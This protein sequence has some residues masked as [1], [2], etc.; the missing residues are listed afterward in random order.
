VD[1]VCDAVVDRVRVRRGRAEGVEVAVRGERRMASA[2][3]VV[4]A[5]G[6]VASPLVLMRS[7]LGPAS[8]LSRHGIAPVADLPRVGANLHDHLLAAGNVYRATRPVPPSRLQHSE[9]LMYVRR[10]PGPAPDLV[11]ACV[12]LPVVSEAFAAPPV[13]AAFTIMCGFTHPRS[14]GRVGLGGPGAL[15]PPVIDPAYLAE[16][17]DRE[18]FRAS[19][20]LAREVAG[21]RALDP[22]RSEELLPGPAVRTAAGLDDFLARAAVTHHHPVGTCGMGRE[23]AAAVVDGA[24]RVHGVERLRIADASV[25]PAITTGPVNATVVAVAERAAEL[26]A[27]A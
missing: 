24:L 5:A 16:P 7:G 21:R 6:A 17:E 20:A 23:P 25:I 11:L 1:L 13:G 18:A 12:V 8:E 26:I 9:S 10:G 3:L 27:A 19:L 2:S 15:D 14:R 4:L 22:W